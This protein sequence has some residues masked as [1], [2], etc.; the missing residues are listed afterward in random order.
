[1][2]TG[3][4][5][6]RCRGCWGCRSCCSRSTCCAGC[7]PAMVAPGCARR[8]IRRGGWS[9][10]TR[11][12][13][14]CPGWSPSAAA[15]SSATPGIPWPWPWSASSSTT[16][17]PA[18]ACPHTCSTWAATTTESRRDSTCLHRSS[19]P[20][21][22]AVSCRAAPPPVRVPRTQVSTQGCQAVAR[23]DDD[24]QAW[25][26]L[27]DFSHPDGDLILVNGGDLACV[28]RKRTEATY[29][30]AKTAYLGMKLA[31]IALAG[32]DLLADRLLQHSEPDE[33][34]V[35]LAAPPVAAQLDPENYYG[36]LP[37]TT[38]V[39]T[40]QCADTMPVYTSGSTRTY[41]SDQVFADLHDPRRVARRREGL[42][43]GWLPAVH[44]V[45]PI[46]A[47]HWYDVLVFADFDATDRFVVQTWHRTMLVEHGKPGRV[48]YGHSYPAYPPRRSAPDAAAFYRALLRFH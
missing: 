48:S 35:R 7:R 47:E 25:E 39:G 15:A 5:G 38:F 40:R 29:D 26:V 10:T 6:R 23:F 43:G 4:A 36:R 9:P 11:C 13:S 34:Q 37:W 2:C 14:R 44:K 46:D 12:S 28:L 3:R 30:E 31:D 21:I 33:Q 19:Q 24:T 1:S 8:C 22:V 45:V 42:L 18:P 32:A 20:W 41:H 17:A 27:E 16:G